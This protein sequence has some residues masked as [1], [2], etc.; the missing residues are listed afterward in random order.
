MISK[1]EIEKQRSTRTNSNERHNHKWKPLID[2]NF[3][4]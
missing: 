3:V 2:K 1:A 4:N